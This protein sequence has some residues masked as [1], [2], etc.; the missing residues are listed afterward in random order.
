MKSAYEL[1]MERLER[2]DPGGVKSLTDKQR[3]ELKIIDDLY[4]SKIAEKEV[5]LGGQLVQASPE[6]QAQ[7]E[8]QLVNERERLREE[9]EV[10]KEKVRKK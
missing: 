7:I 8:E 9:C 1:A 4:T 10:K 2:E 3:N 5:F 6:E